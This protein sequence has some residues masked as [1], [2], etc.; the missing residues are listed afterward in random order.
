MAIFSKM[1]LMNEFL[2][3]KNGV[4]E[5]QRALAT[6]RVGRGARSTESTQG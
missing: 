2:H 5:I 3:E 1:S 6:A 4:E